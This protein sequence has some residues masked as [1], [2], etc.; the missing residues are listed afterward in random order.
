MRKITTVL[1]SI[2]IV[3]IQSCSNDSETQLVPD[4]T[5][6]SVS[7][8]IAGVPN[9]SEGGTVVVGSQI[10]VNVDAKDE[11]GIAKIEAFINDQKVGE[12]T[13]PPYSLTIDLSSF[14]SKVGKT[15]KFVDYVLK[16]VAT[17]IAGNTT[18]TEQKIHIDGEIPTI[19]N[20]SL[21]AGTVIGGNAN[22]MTFEVMDNETLSTILVYINDALIADID[23]E[24]YDVNL[25]T[26]LLTDGENALK[27]EVKDLAGNIGSHNVAFIVDNTGPEITLESLVDGQLI[28]T[29]INLNPVVVD[30]YSEV[31][32][33]EI[34]YGDE[35]IHT[36]A[37]VADVNVDFDPD[38]YPTGEAIIKIKAIDHLGN[39][40]ELMLHINVLRLLFTMTVPEGYLSPNIPINHFVFASELDGTLIDLKEIIFETREVKLYA[41][42]EFDL[43]K[44]FTITFASLGRNGVASYLFSVAHLNRGN[45]KQLDLVVPKRFTGN[46]ATSY[47]INGFSET[48][49]LFCFGRDFYFSSSESGATMIQD[50]TPSNH[51]AESDPIYI[52][53]YNPL[54]N[55]YNHLTV[56]RP[57][58]SDF[59]INFADFSVSN[60]E[61]SQ[62]I[63]TPSGFLS[64]N[65]AYL[66]L[67]GFL[68]QEGLDNELYRQIWGYGRTPV[69]TFNYQLN[70][71][72]FAYA[73][74]LKIGNYFAKG[75]GLP[76]GNIIIPNWTVDYTFQNNEISLTT[77]GTGHTVGEILLE[78]GYD[79]GVP[80]QWNVFFDSN[81]AGP[82]ILPNISGVL[83][84]YPFFNLYQNNTLEVNRVGLRRYDN[85]SNYEGYL[86]QIIKGNKAFKK[87]S[88]RY[89]SIYSGNTT[90]EFSSSDYF[91][92]A[93]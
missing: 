26:S 74:D 62:I 1:T 91:H 82:I 84:S 51:V 34:F 13:D 89:E 80:Y 7:L 6:P 2:L 9:S 47:P 90:Q 40:S 63:T 53:G 29:T 19:T 38:N 18:A 81:K 22:S 15:T 50:F 30:A 78:G 17:D 55:F 4:T 44:D 32:T 43:E 39:S 45:L 71:Q 73:Y 23:D 52:Y 3:V 20:V 5:A 33:V 49:Q 66:Q 77:S 92:N 65:S 88:P 14:T 56:D 31:G 75:V 27:I 83:E 76:E 12:D 58:A 64:S 25:D 69:T 36:A 11:G 24:I 70:T 54:N 10:V 41:S 61:D 93:W 86:A 60:V 68:D 48:T 46:G 79:V 28:D 35:I 8:S 57:I 85:I 67:Y 21:L 16:I 72:F 87:A 42:G 37:N 59:E